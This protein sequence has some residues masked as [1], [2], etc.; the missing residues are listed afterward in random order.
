MAGEKAR[1]EAEKANPNKVASIAA[2]EPASPDT[3]KSD[4]PAPPDIP[5]LL[6]TEL[7]RVGCKSGDAEGEWNAASRR[8]LSLFN[9]NAGTKF[10]TKLASIDALDAVK[11]KTGRVCPL[12]CER[13]F[14]GDGDHCVKI[15]CESDQVLGPNGTC[16]ARPERAPKV[17]A[18]RERRTPAVSGHGRCFAFNGRQVCE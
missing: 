1:L 3:A 8:A 7:R 11:A 5:R 2:T 13:G 12:D 4:C 14:R 9:D 15:T 6:Q 10:D 18:H 16:R 17:V